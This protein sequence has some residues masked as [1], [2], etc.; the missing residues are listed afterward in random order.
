LGCGIQTGAGT[1][2]NAAKAGPE[3]TVCVLGLGGVGLSAVMGAKIAGSRIVIGVDRVASR[4][5]LAK[6]MGATH[7][8]DGSNLPEG[9]TLVQV[10]REI[11]DGLGPSVT[12]DTTGAP[13]LVKAAIEFAGPVGKVCQVGTCPFD[14]KL[15]VE[16]FSYMIRGIQYIGAIEGQAYPPEFVPKMVQWYREGRFPIDKMI[17]IM[18]VDKFNDALHEMHEGS[19]IKPVLA[20]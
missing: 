9:K 13:A 2:L 19:T 14:F 10:V 16:V 7:V 20:W 6:E 17:K 15:E 3:D 11:A 12:V 4:L 5:A 1:V 8:I 18:P